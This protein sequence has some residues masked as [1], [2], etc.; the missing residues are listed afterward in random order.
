MEGG[1]GSGVKISYP[2]TQEGYLKNLFI[3]IS[4]M[5]FLGMND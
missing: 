1:Q 3:I 5:K 4:W 2:Y